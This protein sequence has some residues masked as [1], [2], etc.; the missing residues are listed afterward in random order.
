MASIGHGPSAG[1][2]RLTGTDVS[3]LDHR[4]SLSWISV[5]ILMSTFLFFLI[6]AAPG[7]GTN[8]PYSRA[9]VQYSGFIDGEGSDKDIILAGYRMYTVNFTFDEVLL[10]DVESFD[11]DLEEVSSISGN[12][13]HQLIS[14]DTANSSLTQLSLKGKVDVKGLKIS[15]G[16]SGPVE[17]G[18]GLF[19]HLRWDLETSLRLLPRLKV[20]G[21]IAQL[22]TAHQVSLSIW[23]DLDVTSPLMTHENGSM[24]E[25][26]ATLRSGSLLTLSGLKVNYIHPTESFSM[27][28]PLPEELSILV[29]DTVSDHAFEHISDSF[30]TELILPRTLTDKVTL[31]IIVKDVRSDW[32]FRVRAWR[33]EVFTDD[34]SPT[35]SLKR[36]GTDM[37]VENEDFE[38]EVQFQDQPAQSPI[39]VNG[40]S[41]AYRVKRGA[42][43]SVWTPIP[44]Q[45]DLKTI[46]YLGTTKGMMG[47]GNTSLQYRAS[48]TL[49]NVNISSIYPIHINVPP[50]LEVPEIYRDSVWLSN[51]S[52]SLDG[53]R[54]AIDPDNDDLGYE[55]YIEDVDMNPLSMN[56]IFNR[57]LFNIEE[58][59]HSV[60]LVVKDGSSES[61]VRF[62]ITVKKVKDNGEK[63]TLLDLLRNEGALYF[64]IPI[65]LLIAIIIVVPLI[66]IVHR[67]TRDDTDFVVDENNT[68]SNSQADEMARKLRELYETST[69]FSAD[70]ENT[71]EMD[72][73]T[74][75]DFNYNL[76]ELLG[77]DK[78]ATAQDIK[79]KYRD[80]AAFYH[81]DRVTQHKEITLETA[82]EKM[83]M[84][85]KTKEILLNPELRARYD[86]SISD[87]DFSID[88]NDVGED[89]ENWG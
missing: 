26:R 85:N 70:G 34:V 30:R 67:R 10:P 12:T 37:R 19:F 40:S 57:T 8:G 82:I 87:M 53:K 35:I 73:S 16:P 88:I 80:M 46:S 2:R 32:L 18:I 33:F 76:Y 69:N 5:I 62:N 77:L 3:F 44:P 13:L 51:M 64:I 24:I 15:Q 52:L 22:D 56:R 59:R 84:I 21:S 31:T 68:M 86:A 74:E 83:I 72:L 60:K 48:D 63:E 17:V 20:N 9:L 79:R 7:T 36:P 6:A 55:W 43:W 27:F 49:G 41:L 11:V 58:G 47:A 14:Y 42:T 25:D 39:L 71:A 38:F 4:S 45:K 65:A 78:T 50:T 29:N 75:F 61:E 1:A 28:S 23:G 66:I 54:F 81:P 89:G